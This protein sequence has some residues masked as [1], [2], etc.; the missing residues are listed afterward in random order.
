MMLLASAPA[1]VAGASLSDQL[2]AARERARALGTAIERQ[3]AL[4]R[5]LERDQ[6]ST[7]AAL[8]ATA[9]ELDAI[10]ADQRE[11]RR[12][13]EDVIVRLE[14]VE[15]RHAVLVDELRQADYTLGLLE[16]ELASGEEDLAARRAALGARLA[17]AYRVEN[18]PLLEQLFTADSFTDV[19]S[20]AAADLAYGDQDARMAREIATD[21]QALDMLRLL[22]SSTRLRTEQLRRETIT[23]R[24]Q[25]EAR[26]AELKAAQQRLAELERKTE[27]IQQR[28]AERYRELAGT[29][30]D[31]ERI[32]RKQ[33]A[34]ERALRARIAGL[35]RAAQV[36]AARRAG[37]VAPGQAGGSFDWP[38][39]GIV[40]QE[41]GCTGFYLE[42]PRGT[43]A[44]FHDGIDIANGTGTPIRAAADG[45][46]AFVGFRS[47]GS[48]MV[49][50]GHAG[51]YETSY[52]HMLPRYVVRAGDFVE[53]G[54]V[55]GYMSCTGTCT[56]PHVHWEVLKDG[57]TI[58]PRGVV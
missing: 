11:V 44:H 52:G 46:V 48:F 33:A 15:A 38:A 24:D 14:R 2:A 10:N 37:G 9:S 28:Y 42:P 20:Q 58:D 26:K 18:T 57:Q 56:G 34:A 4:I 6:A 8:A 47:D 55:I 25:I 51:G 53:Q 16:Q 31:A 22:T 29:K 32:A 13:I 41:Y 12:R 3:D 27:R 45:V 19:L 7:Q 35:V 49:V 1:M 40:T 17:E 5:E 36:A 23:T 39:S 21:Q 30:R 43:C 54:K 50:M